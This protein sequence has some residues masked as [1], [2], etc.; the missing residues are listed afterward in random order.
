MT[1]PHLIRSGLMAH[2]G[3]ATAAMPTD[4]GGVVGGVSDRELGTGAS[5]DDDF[6]AGVVDLDAL[7]AW[8]DSDEVA[9]AA[10]SD[11]GGAMIAAAGAIPTVAAT[12]GVAD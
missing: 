4:T 12:A 7:L 8:H 6:F 1:R 10:P 5:A 3:D 9:T 11:V 2:G